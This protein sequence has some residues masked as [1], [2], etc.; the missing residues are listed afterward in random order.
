MPMNRDIIRTSFVTAIYFSCAS[1]V[2]LWL[3]GFLYDILQKTS[4]R[5]DI[6]WVIIIVLTLM[7]IMFFLALTSIL[8][9]E[10]EHKANI[11][12]KIIGVF[13]FIIISVILVGSLSFLFWFPIG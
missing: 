5:L 12:D 9:G 10:H 1:F 7:L 11:M 13:L 4:G 2:I 8:L 6:G 3:A